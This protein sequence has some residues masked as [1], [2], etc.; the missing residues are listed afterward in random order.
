MAEPI[1]TSVVVI[2]G[3]LAG[4]STALFLSARNVPVVVIERHK[5]S[6]VHPRAIG[7]THRTI[8]LLRSVGIEDR[9]PSGRSKKGSG[10][11]RRVQ[12]DSLS[13]KWHDE[14]YWT[15]PTQGGKPT[16][17][18]SGPSPA[19]GPG[20]PGGPG[21]PSQGKGPGGPPGHDDV[22]RLSPCNA[23]AIAQDNMEPLLRNRAVELGA[24]IRTGCKMV[25]FTQDEAG[26]TVT[27]VNTTSGDEFTIQAKYMVACDGARSAVREALGIKRSGVG[28]LRTLRSIMFRC[29]PIDKYLEHGIGQFTYDTPEFEGF[30]TTYMDGRWALMEH[31]KDPSAPHPDPDAQRALIRLAVGENEPLLD[32]DIELLTE[33]QWDLAAL[34]ADRFSDGRV[35]LAGDAAHTLPPNRGGYGANTGIA[36]AYDAAWKLAAVLSEKS[37]PALLETYDAERRPV[38]LVRH[39]QIFARDDYKQYLDPKSEWATKEIPILDDI[40]M[41]LGQLYRSDAIVSAELESLPDARRPDEWAGQ[42]GT[43]APHLWLNKGSEKISTL[44]LFGKGW[45]LVSEDDDWGKITSITSDLN[46]SKCEFVQIGGGGLQPVDGE[47][48]FRKAFGLEASGAALIRPDG[49]VAWRTVESPDSTKGRA[50]LDAFKKAACAQLYALLGNNRAYA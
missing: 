9:I 4:L 40:A 32:S 14:T 36:D 30:L 5:D 19:G 12:V 35:L 24:D 8:E 31:L 13:G 2:G 50:L 27:A 47:D 15:K 10:K 16:G 33:G 18:P 6:S 42:P 49:F 7:Y 34:I 43:R 26:V 44:D 21:Q 28:P 11:P 20:A 22:A 25:S 3:S 17:G 29:P 1:Q 37:T 48:A 23:T 45:V 41:E 39:D 38:A 46:S